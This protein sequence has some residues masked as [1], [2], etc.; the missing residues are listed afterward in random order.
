[1]AVKLELAGVK[2]INVS[3]AGGTSWAAVERYRAESRSMGGKVNLG[4]L[5]W[6]WGIPT[7]ASLIEVRK[8][9]GVP[10]IAS[11]GLR[12]GLDIAKCMAL[13]ANVCGMASP[14]LKAAANGIDALRSF[15][16]DV[17]S[18]IRTAMFVTGSKNIESLRRARKVII[19]PLSHW[20]G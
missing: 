11:G 13:G 15:A 14:M 17:Q 10:V 16:E 2:A 7:A 9:V 6:D 12:N 1:V 4:D 18:E 3:G 8:A 19:P 20:V 5:F